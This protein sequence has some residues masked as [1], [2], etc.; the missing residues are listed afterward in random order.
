VGF[1]L[2]FALLVFKRI[3][4]TDNPY[5]HTFVVEVVDV[6]EI[7]ITVIKGKRFEE[8]KKE[9]YKLIATWIL[10]RRILHDWHIREGVDGGPSDEG[11]QST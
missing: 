11:L 9:C 4:Q 1:E 7:R 5:R 8:A 6:E 3:E 2:V 10:N